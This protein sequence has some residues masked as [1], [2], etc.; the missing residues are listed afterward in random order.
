MNIKSIVS[1]G[2]ATA[3][4]FFAIGLSGSNMG[5]PE[6]ISMRII[7]ILILVIAFCIVI[8]YEKTIEFPINLSYI[9]LIASLLVI[10]IWILLSYLFSSYKDLVEVRDILS[11]VTIPIIIIMT[12]KII[13]YIKPKQFLNTVTAIQLI[14]LIIFYLWIYNNLGSFIQFYQLRSFVNTE[15]VIGLNRFLNGLVFLSVIS[16]IFVMGYTKINRTIYIIS[17]LNILLTS[18]VSF[19]TGS[20]QSLMGLF[21]ILLISYL[22]KQSIKVEINFKRMFSVLILVIVALVFLQQEEVRYWIND[23]FFSKTSEQLI[24]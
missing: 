1:I 21:S 15:L 6:N 10:L 16:I 11:W 22:F 5:L 20:R 8:C 18:Y 2:S 17:T 23:R 13:K 7:A 19:A 12:S 9:F 4:S 24:E 3:Y 14:T